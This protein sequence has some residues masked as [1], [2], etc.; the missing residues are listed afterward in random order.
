MFIFLSIFASFSVMNTLQLPD[1]LDVLPKPLAPQR[2]ISL[3]VLS[4]CWTALGIAWSCEV[5]G[6]SLAACTVA[7]KDSKLGVAPLQ[8]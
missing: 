8:K 4:D 5:P 7:I 2:L 3:E 6:L 1:K